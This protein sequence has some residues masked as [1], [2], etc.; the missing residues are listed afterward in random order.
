M[1][2]VSDWLRAWSRSPAKSSWGLQP[3]LPAS[4]SFTASMKPRPLLYSIRKLIA[5]PWAPQPKQW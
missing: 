2:S 5:L 3:T 1:S 4:S